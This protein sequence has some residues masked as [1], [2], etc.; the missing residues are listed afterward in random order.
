[1]SAAP[2]PTAATYEPFKRLTP[3]RNPFDIHIYFHHGDG[4]RA[5]A[6]NLISVIKGAFPDFRA[7]PCYEEPIGPHPTPSFLSPAPSPAGWV[8]GSGRPTSNAE[9]E[10]KRDRIGRLR[11]E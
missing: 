5:K 9:I 2:L 10:F 11:H 8:G 1:M 7:Y 6:E 4:S 3:G